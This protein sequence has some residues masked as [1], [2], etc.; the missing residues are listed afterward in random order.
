MSAWWPI[1]L[2]IATF[3]FF[4]AGGALL[5]TWAGCYYDCS[6]G[7][8]YG[9]IALIVIA[10]F[11][12]IAWIVTLVMYIRSRRSGYRASANSK[13]YSNAGTGLM[14]GRNFS[15]SQPLAPTQYPFAS[16]AQTQ[17]SPVPVAAPMYDQM[18]AKNQATYASA[19]MP[20][21]N[22]PGGIRYCIQC[23]ATVHT[24][25]CAHCGYANPM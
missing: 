13:V 14:D 10:I 11:L 18:P 6:A 9:G 17:Y 16:P 2:G 1:S 25:F 22:A 4:I 20:A 23:G 12:K 21:Q 8:Y 7:N 19:E 5:G 24:P 15:S 3:I